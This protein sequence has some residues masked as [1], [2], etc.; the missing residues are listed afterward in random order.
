MPRKK[1][2]NFNQ[3]KY[4]QEFEK[5]RYYKTSLR[6]PKTET[7][8]LDKLNEVESKNGYI[9]DLIKKDIKK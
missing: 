4:I 3:A 7:K 2:G 6:I 5:E 1:S 8:V 9:L